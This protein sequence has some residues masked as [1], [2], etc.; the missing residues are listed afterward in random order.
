MTKKTVTPFVPSQGEKLAALA[1][2][3]YEIEQILQLCSNWPQHLGLQQNA[4]LEATLIHTRQLLDFFEDSK[5][6]V[7]KRREND[8]ILAIDFGFTPQPIALDPTFRERLN[9]DL[10]HLS[11]SRQQRTGPAKSWD[12]TKLQPLL[13]RSHGFAQHICSTWQ[14]SLAAGEAQR[15][16]KLTQALVQA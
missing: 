7:Y 5:R 11:Y 2:V 14:S 4:W 8:D 15:W 16:A 6:S 12:L 9:K 3:A 13:E 10:V 1:D